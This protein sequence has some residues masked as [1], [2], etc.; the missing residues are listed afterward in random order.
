MGEIIGRV[1]IRNYVAP[2]SLSTIVT[3]GLILN[4]DAGNMA[5]YPG[6]G[7][8][9]TDL[10]GL[11]N[12]VTLVNGTTY[13]SANGGTMVFDGVNDYGVGAYNSNLDLSTNNFT[14]EGWFN[15]TSFSTVKL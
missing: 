11:N 13:S 15:S 10:S 9:W 3:N 4:I 8:A 14:L 7:T 6:T 1:G 5:S 12:T 2:A